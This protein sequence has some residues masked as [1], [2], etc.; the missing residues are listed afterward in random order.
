[1]K[2]IL[3]GNTLFTTLLLVFTSAVILISLGYAPEARLTPI[4][5]GIPTLALGVLVL[6]GERYPKLLRQLDVSIMEMSDSSG[7]GSSAEEAGRTEE[8]KKLMIMIGWMVGFFICIY[9][10]GFLVGIPMFL[11]AFLKV[12][13]QSSWVRAIVVT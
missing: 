13:A 9:L 5:I 6:V 11:F 3:T 7:Q 1:M 2:K 12:Y 8:A 10:V 4:I